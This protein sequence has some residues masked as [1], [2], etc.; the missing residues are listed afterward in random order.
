M[1][2]TKNDITV[3]HIY[4]KKISQFSLGMTQGILKK[5]NFNMWWYK[6]RLVNIIS[7]I[8]SML[9]FAQRMDRMLYL[10][11]LCDILMIG[12]VFDFWPPSLMVSNWSSLETLWISSTV[13]SLLN[14]S[15]ML[16]PLI[17]T[18]AL[19]LGV[20]LIIKILNKNYFKQ[21]VHSK[22]LKNTPLMYF[23][24]Q[25][26]FFFLI[27]GPGAG[28]RLGLFV[29]HHVVRLASV[30]YAIG[31]MGFGFRVCWYNGLSPQLVSIIS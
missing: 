12:C 9:F 31:L 6:L 27:K 26:N 24:S 11:D 19:F 10:Y 30:L 13:I 18:V 1:S 28:V 5:K 15:T 14:L 17:T 20:Q 21:M 29:L 16:L 3:D 8:K 7:I 22:F 2:C 25:L 4:H 23:Q